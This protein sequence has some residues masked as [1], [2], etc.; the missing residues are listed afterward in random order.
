MGLLILILWCTHEHLLR[1]GNDGDTYEHLQFFYFFYNTE[2]MH[3]NSDFEEH[4]HAY[5][6][7]HD[8]KIKCELGLCRS[9]FL[10]QKR[11]F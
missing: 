5:T 10:E 9:P 2:I 7:V 11:G 3:S 8:Q 6:L 4:M 1:M